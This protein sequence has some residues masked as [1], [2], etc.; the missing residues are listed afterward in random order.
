MGI[1]NLDKLFHPRCVAVIGASEKKGSVGL[2]LMNN[3]IN[4]SF[5]GTI[6]PINPKQTMILGRQAHGSVLDLKTPPDLAVIAAPIAF[7]PEIIRDCAGMGVGGAVIISAGGKEIGARGQAIENEIRSA[8]SGSNLRIIGPNCIGIISAKSHLNASF[9]RGM[10]L[11]G[12]MAFIS[13][14]GAICTSVLD[15]SLKEKIGFSYFISLGSMLDVDFGDAIDFLGGEPGVTSIVMYV[16]SLTRFRNFMSAARAVSRVKPIIALKAGRS[17]AGARAAASHTGAL[18][19]NDAVYDAAFKRAGVLRVKTFEELF[20]CAGLAAKQ[21]RPDGPALVIMTNAG[22]PGVMASDALSDYGV[23]PTELSP[24]TVEE[25]NKILPPHWSHANP[26]DML[27]DASPEI[28]RKVAE[29]CLKSSKINGLL[30]L[31]SPQALDD[32]TDVAASIAGLF[33]RK[34][35]PVLAAWIGGDNLEKGRE[36]L[37][38]A[39]VPTFDT[40]ERA[41]RAFMDLHQYSR[42]IEMLQEIPPRISRKISFDKLK[43]SALIESALKNK[44]RFLTE[45][46]ANAL[47]AAYGIPVNPIKIAVNADEAVQHA[48]AIGYPVVMKIHSRDISHKTDANGVILDL[49]SDADVRI[50]FRGIMDSAGKFNPKAVLEGV[51]IQAMITDKGIEL[52]LG[53]KKDRDFGPV[54]LFGMGGVMTEILADR[55]VGLPPINRLLARRLMQ[56]TKVFQ[57]LGGSRGR[58]SANFEFLEEI[59][60]RLSQL[61]IDFADIQE[62]DINPLIVSQDQIVAVD[63]RVIISPSAVQSPHHLV[64]SSYP[65]EHEVYV[66]VEGVENLLIRPI[67]P[68]DA[69]LMEAMFESLSPRSIYMRFFTPLKRMDY[70]MLARFT[71]IDYDRHIA[72]TAI[73]E[74]SGED[75]ML[76]VARVIME[77]NLKQAEFS[78]II[79]DPWQGRGIGAELLK[80][81]IAIARKHDV[82][83]IYGVVLAENRQML[84]LGRKLGFT[85]KKIPEV[86]EYELRLEL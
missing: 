75:K 58:P 2:A 11:N 39:G 35:F 49:R 57:L 37:N 59:L 78:V 20:D 40:A 71:Q 18:A 44:N 15:L 42:N 24:T 12:K 83:V 68:E 43:A 17:R 54:L 38:Q 52:I 84:A 62:L 80:R 56:E 65:A 19:G 48:H 69:S 1:E 31:L 34:S 21:P 45:V 67:K 64:I 79:G 6:Y 70:Q 46:E 55:A 50:A 29:V 3:I 28:Y 25:L 33:T 4:S 63:A 77:R 73:S 85:I 27:G 26:I 36:I 82:K 51:T 72:L 30:I 23:E 16:E 47:L 9:A 5:K 32:P 53:S 14:S 10:P 81:C 61:V 7:V 60:I 74:E 22:G 86:S 41:V 13:Q 8:A 76:G 66:S